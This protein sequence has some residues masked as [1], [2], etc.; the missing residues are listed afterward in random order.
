LLVERD[1][2][3]R[4]VKLAALFAREVGGSIVLETKKEDSSLSV[5]A[6]ASEIGENDSEIATEV[7]GDGK[8][9]LNSRFVLDAINVISDEKV[10]FGF[11]DK[12]APVVVKG[13]KLQ[14]YV[15]II[16]PLKS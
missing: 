15:H 13:E 12:L 10:K 9:T 7:D 3:A 5:R 4:V 16:M 2:L 14:D 8:I 1:E 6:V 11:S